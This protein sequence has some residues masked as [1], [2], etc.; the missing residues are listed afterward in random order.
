M[1]KAHR[2]FRQPMMR[3]SSRIHLSS[4]NRGK[5]DTLRTFLRLCRDMQQYFV[6]GFWTRQE[7]DSTLA[8]LPIV[9]GGRNKFTTTTRL[10]QAMA[11]QA[12]EAVRSAAELNG[13]K[14]DIRRHVATLCYHFVTVEPFRGDFDFALKLVG[15]GAPRMVVPIK[16]TKHLN[17]KLAAGWMIGNSVRLGVDREDRLYVDLMLEKPRPPLKTTGRV[18]GMDSNYKAGL[19]FS[20]G[21]NVGRDAYVR[22]QEFAKRQ[23]HTH[24]E[25]KSML[26]EAVK[27]IDW[28]NIRVLCVEDLKHV[29]RDT[30]GKF[31]RRLNRRL[32][33]WFYRH[34]ADLLARACE[35]NGVRVEK[36]APWKTSQF[37]RIC[38]KCDRRNRKGDKFECVNCGHLDNS[39]TNAALNL[40]LL[41][42]AECYGIRS[43]IKSLEC[44]SS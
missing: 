1:R 39:D 14:P 42:L 37:C 25:M 28:S 24:A 21:Q 43:L 31:P 27:Q 15:S 33:H 44:Q 41:G 32:S 29:K 7:F 36:K 18:V 17:E 9:H 3:R 5:S 6:D 20:D 34:T 11:K 19:V 2:K 12:K 8:K 13:G 26:G 38:G 22:I 10:A 40:E 4:L 35:E 16:S 23:K 30:R